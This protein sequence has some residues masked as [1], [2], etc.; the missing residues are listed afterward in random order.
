MTGEECGECREINPFL[1]IDDSCVTVGRRGEETRGLLRPQSLHQRGMQ[2]LFT[3]VSR[4]H[5][6]HDLEPGDGIGGMPGLR[7][8]GQKKCQFRCRGTGACGKPGIHACCIGLQGS[9]SLGRQA[10]HG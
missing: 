9:T 1:E 10:G 6:G 3:P 7:L 4:E 2:R 5:E 8:I